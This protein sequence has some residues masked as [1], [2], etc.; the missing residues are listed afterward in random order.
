LGWPFSRKAELCEIRIMPADPRA[1]ELLT[2]KEIL[3]EI[4]QIDLSE[5]EEMIRVR[6]GEGVQYEGR[7]VWPERLWVEETPDDVGQAF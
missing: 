5:A 6:C 7:N 4:F 1:L 2:A 3:A